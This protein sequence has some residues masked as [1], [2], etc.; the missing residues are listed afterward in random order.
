MHHTFA[1]RS[2]LLVLALSMI[3]AGACQQRSAASR[4]LEELATPE[5][6]MR[7]ASAGDGVAVRWARMGELVPQVEA[8]LE[9]DPQGV[10][11]MAERLAGAG[12]FEADHELVVY[13][14][15]FAER[16]EQEVALQALAQTID[17]ELAGG[18][19]Y[20]A[21]HAAAHAIWTLLGDARLDADA[22]Y[23]VA[24]LRE[25]R[26]AARAASGQ[27]SLSLDGPPDGWRRLW[28]L[29]K[30]DG[31]PLLLNGKRVTVDG[32]EWT[33]IG[34]PE[35]LVAEYRE[36]VE[37]GGGTFV[38]LDGAGPNRRFNCAGYAFRELNQGGGW[39]PSAPE[40]LDLL[41][42]AG[43]LREKEGPPEKGDKVF[44]FAEGA[45]A[46][47][48][49]I[50]QADAVA[51]IVRN[52]DNQSG[53][54][55]ARLD[56]EYFETFDSYRVYEWV[57][58]PPGIEE[59]PALDGDLAY[60]N[61]RP[62]QLPKSPED[63]PPDDDY[64]PWLVPGQESC[65]KAKEVVFDSS[66][67]CVLKA[68][69]DVYCWGQ[70]SWGQVGDG[71]TETRH[72]MTRVLGLSG[73]S[74]LVQVSIGNS[75][76]ALVGGQLYCWGS[77]SRTNDTSDIYPG[78]AFPLP[79]ISDV[80]SAWSGCAAK[81]DGSLWCWGPWA[82]YTSDGIHEWQGISGVTHAR[83]RCVIVAKQLMC[84]GYFGESTAGDGVT[85]DTKGEWLPVP[86]ADDVVDFETSNSMCFVREEGTVWCWG[87]NSSGEL[88]DGSGQASPT[89]VRVREVRDVVDLV[90]G[91]FNFC[92]IDA[93]A[94]AW[95]W[96]YNPRE[97][98]EEGVDKNWYEPQRLP[99]SGVA[100]ISVAQSRG[101]YTDLEGRLYC[102]GGSLP[103][104]EV[105]QPPSYPLVRVALPCP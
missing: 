85:Q 91:H 21:A 10:L 17:N 93:N 33:D 34:L 3:G 84:N 20:L 90:A 100:S 74:S 48:G 92:A 4:A 97:P 96:G 53:L 28:Q 86:G 102:W 16:G 94:E 78:G 36:R 13:A 79:G 7:L 31:S 59:D 22:W 23:S 73:A 8:L 56:A 105:W 24:T 47:V 5:A 42:R 87:E 41:T 72:A 55:D 26:D 1:D 45:A 2:V 62:P 61:G 64:V 46:H 50:Q 101:C 32:K 63:D 89:P 49:E 67:G 37:D 30:S 15:V 98:F 75:R 54:F 65:G 70:N 66:G 11:D 19:L 35:S 39:N 14:W 44:W 80:V 103:H 29:T 88:G 12:T 25:A 69:G 51:P 27:A 77:D 104:G 40:M 43:A 52:A 60:C 83:P 95:C 76:C 71:T 99:F 57:D 82:Q 38:D 68:D 6:H 81:S 58:A 18:D 9:A